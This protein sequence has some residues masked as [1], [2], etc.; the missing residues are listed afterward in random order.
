ML[1]VPEFDANDEALALAIL[2]REAVLLHPG[3][4]FDFPRGAHL[5][6]SLLTP[7]S[8]PCARLWSLTAL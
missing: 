7:I 4:F 5:V 6:L 1:R 8:A 3:Y 2:E